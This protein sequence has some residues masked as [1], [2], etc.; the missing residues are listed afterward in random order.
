MALFSDEDDE[1]EQMEKM[2]HIEECC[3]R[4]KVVIDEA[5]DE[6]ILY[7][8]ITKWNEARIVSYEMTI[9]ARHDMLKGEGD[10]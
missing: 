1:F 3:E 8:L 9:L 2:K 4:A 5:C 10:V 6:N 7:D